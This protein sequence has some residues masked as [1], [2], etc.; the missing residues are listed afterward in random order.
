MKNI[1]VGGV[2]VNQPP[3]GINSPAFQPYQRTVYL[4]PL[5]SN[6]CAL[7]CTMDARNTF[8][9]NRLRTLSMAMGVY[10][11]LAPSLSNA[12]RLLSFSREAAELKLIA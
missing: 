5:F 9:F 3:S 7:L 4:S 8:A 11:L 6:S 2:I 10:N 1:G 12:Y